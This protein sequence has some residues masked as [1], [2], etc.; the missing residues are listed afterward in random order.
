MLMI[1][2]KLYIPFELKT[3]K[4]TKYSFKAFQFS[5]LVGL[6]GCGSIT[7]SQIQAQFI[8]AAISGQAC[9]ELQKVPDQSCQTKNN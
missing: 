6:V 5:Q 3:L 9:N 7:T 8:G 4:K 2:C 1:K